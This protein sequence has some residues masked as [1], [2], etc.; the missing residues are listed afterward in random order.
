ME[1]LEQQAITIAPTEMKPKLCKS[2][3]D[4]IFEVVKKTK[5]SR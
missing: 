1:D 5:L 2:Y 3:V 4:D